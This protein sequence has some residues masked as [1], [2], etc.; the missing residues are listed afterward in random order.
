MSIRPLKETCLRILIFKGL[1]TTGVW[2]L[3]SDVA[4]WVGQVHVHENVGAIFNAAQLENSFVSEKCWH[5]VRPEKLL[6]PLSGGVSDAEPVFPHCIQV[7]RKWVFADLKSRSAE[8][9][10]GVRTFNTLRSTFHF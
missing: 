6:A 5:F 10:P 1:Q 4:Y 2:T 3:H 9:A 7:H 8:K